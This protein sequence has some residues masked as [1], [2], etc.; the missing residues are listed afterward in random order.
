MLGLLSAHKI[1]IAEMVEVCAIILVF[2]ILLY[3]FIIIMEKL[4]TFIIIDY[5]KYYYCIR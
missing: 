1:S 2:D 3:I 4:F 5:H